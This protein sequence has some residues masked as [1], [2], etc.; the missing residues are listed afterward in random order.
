MAEGK[1]FRHRVAPHPFA[2]G[3]GIFQE[4]PFRPMRAAGIFPA[5]ESNLSYA[6]I[7]NWGWQ[8]AQAY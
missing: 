3:R 7:K 6:P 1:E 4:S 2:E 8:E 5:P